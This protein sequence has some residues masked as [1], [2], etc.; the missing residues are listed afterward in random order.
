MSE[1]R[2]KYLQLKNMP[3]DDFDGQGRGN[4]YQ[5]S[6]AD[7]MKMD[8]EQLGCRIHKQHQLSPE[9]KKVWRPHGDSNPGYRRE[10]AMS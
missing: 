9:G 6:M 10:R 4:F 5:H 1:P 2:F 8:P 3:A 7:K